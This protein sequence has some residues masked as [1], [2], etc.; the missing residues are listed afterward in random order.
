MSRSAIKLICSNYENA[1]VLIKL[2]WDEKT[3]RGC[4]KKRKKR[5]LSRNRNEWVNSQVS[6]WVNKWVIDGLSKW[7]CSSHAS[8]SICKRSTKDLQR[9]KGFILCNRIFSKTIY[10]EI[11]KYGAP[12]FLKKIF[13]VLQA[14]EKSQNIYNLV[15]QSFR[16]NK[17]NIP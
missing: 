13:V 9:L 17:M 6:E 5:E 15:G 11:I 1:H 3:R 8:T 10:M 2:N 16:L 12:I 7:Q 14:Y 4:L